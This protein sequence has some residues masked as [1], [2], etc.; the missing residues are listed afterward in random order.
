MG[1]ARKVVGSTNR[2]SLRMKAL[3][4]YTH[5]ERKGTSKYSAAVVMC[6]GWSIGDGVVVNERE[7]PRN[8]D[9]MYVL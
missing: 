8:R 3:L 1:N 2:S 9:T 6:G 7:E 5:L 4:F